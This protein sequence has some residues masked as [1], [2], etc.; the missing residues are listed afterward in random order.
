MRRNMKRYAALL[1]AC[2]LALTACSGTASSSTAAAESSQEAAETP[3]AATATPTD[4]DTIE[5]LEIDWTQASQLPLTG[6]YTRAFEDGRTVK[7][8][9]AEDASIR[10]YFTVV[11]VPNGV[12]TTEFLSENGWF[13]LADQK[14]EGL[15]VLEPGTDGWG[16]AEAESEYM[17][18]AIG[19]L[20]GTQN[21]K[22]VSVFSTFGE[23]Y[24]AAYGESCEAVELWAAQNP[25]LVISQV[26]V[27]GT[28][29]SADALAEA[30]KTEYDGVKAGGYADITDFEGTLEKVGMKVVTKAEVP[31]PTWFVNY[32]ADSANI[33]YWKSANDTV[34][35]SADGVY[36][37]GIDSDA[38]QTEQ[39]NAEVLKLDANAKYGISQVKVTD[40]EPTA[41][42]IY[43]FLSV[44]TRYENSFAYANTLAY[45]VD[46]TAA[47]VGA[48]QQAKAGTAIATFASKDY[49]GND[50][51]VELWGK[52]DTK[53]E[54]GTVQVG[55]FTF[56][57]N[58]EDGKND[59]REYLV[60]VP[61]SSKG[62]EAPVLMV[63]PGNTQTDGIFFDCTQWYQV[64]DREGFVFVVVNETYSG[65]TAI[66]HVDSL[67]YQTA[68][69][70]VLKEVVDGELATL[71]FSRVYGTGQSL[72]SMTTQGMART[73]P[74]FFAAVAATS[75]LTNVESATDTTA[76]SGKSMPV[77]L[78]SGQSD[79]EFLLPDLWGSKTITD[80]AQYFLGVNGMNTDV[81]SGYE[82]ET[83]KINNYNRINMY[84]W[85]NDQGIPMVKWGQTQM[86]AH[87]CYSG[88]MQHLWD[89]LEHFSF[90][91]AEDGTITRY[92]SASAF[93]E[94]DAVEIK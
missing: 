4:F 13:D 51:T 84:T 70:T 26:Y 21:A 67:Y 45:R 55:V 69:T 19:F 61:D 12:D 36:Y 60:Y 38:L 64:A 87:N 40:A 31:V 72:G 52:A 58:N 86:R 22:E 17:A 33:E 23:F 6:Y 75:G 79:L 32:A 80:W 18:E 81:N 30:G 92:Y 89:Y 8:Y 25:I 10:S 15:F 94:D 78:L 50:V 49:E 47:R 68:I 57:D 20:R 93:A 2:A 9:I 82:N 71:D 54:N 73:N 85:S 91:V 29:L 56:S 34:A 11:A 46:Y 16:T 88:E 76:D 43:A 24:L 48:Q 28:G 74:E 14:G 65:P 59:P 66:T 7:V 53:T 35:E 5:T 44:Y 77:M 41:A 1:L 37:Q 83:V 27:G 3:A 39:A 62:K 90:D 63:Y 42:D